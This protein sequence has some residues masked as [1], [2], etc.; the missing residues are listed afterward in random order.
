MSTGVDIESTQSDSLDNI[1]IAV[2][3]AYLPYLECEIDYFRFGW[4]PSCFQCWATSAD[5][6][7]MAITSMVKLVNIENIV[8]RL[9]VICISYRTADISTSDLA[10]AILDLKLLVAC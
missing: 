4:S 1:G 6:V 10:A 8:N 5:V 7:G 9:N 3:T 2:G